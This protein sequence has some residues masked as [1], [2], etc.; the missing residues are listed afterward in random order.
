MFRAEPRVES[1]T[2]ERARLL[3]R[4]GLFLRPR[5]GWLAVARAKRCFLALQIGSSSLAFRA[6]PVLLPHAASI[7]R[8]IKTRNL[9]SSFVQGESSP[10]NPNRS[11]HFSVIRC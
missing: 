10:K 8:K 6:H 3:G 4:D 7:G 11:L 2:S 5:F 1:H 9:N